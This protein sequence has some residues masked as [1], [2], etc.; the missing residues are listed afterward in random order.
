MY[1]P[2]KKEFARQPYLVH[3]KRQMDLIYFPLCSHFTWRFGRAKAGS[4]RHRLV[5][6]DQA[7]NLCY[8]HKAISH[9]EWLTLRGR[10]QHDTPSWLMTALRSL[11]TDAHL[12]SQCSRHSRE[13]V[14]LPEV[15]DTLKKGQSSVSSCS[16]SSHVEYS[17]A[18]IVH[19][20]TG[21]P[22]EPVMSPTSIR[23]GVE[24]HD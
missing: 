20:S 7:R 19:R 13:S 2:Q 17:N 9:S 3:A 22:D 15:F 6:C 14:F 5:S 21:H 24:Q 1:E 16:F 18:N 12:K 23:W 11:V 4:K 10:L 8:I